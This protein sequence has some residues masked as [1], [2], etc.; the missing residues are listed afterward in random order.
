[1]HSDSE[2][3]DDALSGHQKQ[4]AVA[5]GSERRHEQPEITAN[6]L[7]RPRRQPAVANPG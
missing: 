2:G 3:R 1:M 4:A 7:A 5:A 6:M